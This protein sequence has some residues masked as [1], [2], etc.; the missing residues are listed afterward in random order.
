MCVLQ[1]IC[2]SAT[3]STTVE[4]YGR[5]GVEWIFTGGKEDTVGGEDTQKSASTAPGGPTLNDPE[6]SET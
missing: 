6:N 4:L 3:L 1:N 2:R 5:S